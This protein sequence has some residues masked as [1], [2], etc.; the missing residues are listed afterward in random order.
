M[1]YLKLRKLGKKLYFKIDDVADLLRIKASSSKVLCSRYV[2]KGLL[3]RIKNNYYILYEK[4]NILQ[5]DDFFKIANILQVPSY[6]SYMS[7]LTYYQISTQIQRNFIE[8]ACYR[9]SKKFII[10]NSEFLYY[11]MKEKFYFGFKSS[12]GIFIAEKEKALLDC[13]Y[14]YT[15][16]KYKFD[17]DSINFKKFDIKKLNS[18]M[19][20]YP[21]KVKLNVRKICGI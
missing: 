3:V 9:R 20:I 21:D 15:Y 14:L 5:N 11:K 7:A 1:N 4:W 10:K 8:S 19:K 18:F 13:I 17:I 12:D 2:K 16:G 6:I